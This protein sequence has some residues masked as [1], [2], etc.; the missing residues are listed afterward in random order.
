MREL[1]MD[2]NAGND[3][4]LLEQFEFAKGFVEELGWDRHSADLPASRQDDA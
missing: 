1:S 4:R 3:K 2:F